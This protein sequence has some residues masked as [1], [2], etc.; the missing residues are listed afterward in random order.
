MVKVEEINCLSLNVFLCGNS[1]LSSFFFHVNL[2][3]LGDKLYEQYDT[4]NA[5]DIRDAVTY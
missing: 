1:D 5:E 4:D 2:G 3:K